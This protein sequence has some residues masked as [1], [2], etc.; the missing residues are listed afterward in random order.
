MNKNPL[1]LL[2]NVPEWQGFVGTF[3]SDRSASGSHFFFT[4]L[5]PSW[6]DPNRCH[7]RHSPSTLLALPTHSR[8]LLWTYASWCLSNATAT[9]PHTAGDRSWR[10]ERDGEGKRLDVG[11]KAI[12][13][14]LQPLFLTIHSRLPSCMVINREEQGSLYYRQKSF[15]G[16]FLLWDP[17]KAVAL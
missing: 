8:I 1:L 3:S 17:L 7:F 12:W 9:L 6:H 16:P 5:L 10:R 15:Q 4:L 14:S 13:Q 11:W 2:E